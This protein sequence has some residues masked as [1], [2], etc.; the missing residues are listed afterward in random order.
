M[1]ATIVSPRVMRIGGG[2]VSGLAEVLTQFGLTRP[3]MVTDPWMVSSGTV[4]RCLAPLKA[5]GLRVEV[6]SDTVPDPTDAVIEAGVAVRLCGTANSRVRRCGTV[7]G[8]RRH[9]LTAW[10]TAPDRPTPTV[11]ASVPVEPWM[12]D[13][14]LGT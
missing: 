14:A 4:E 10:S 11:L 8:E 1:V 6:F 7:S 12:I 3:L 13:C 9:A 5:A 2:S